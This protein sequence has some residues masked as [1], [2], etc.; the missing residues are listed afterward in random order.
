M[1]PI[2]V[3]DEIGG[4]LFPAACFRDLIGDPFCGWMSC[5]AKPQNLSSAVPHDQQTIEQAK[6]NCRHDEHIHRS[7]PTSVIVQERLP[8][9]RRWFS[10]FDHI[11]GHTR[12]SDIDAE[13]SNSPWIRGAPHSGLAM[14]ISRISLRI[15]GSTVGRPP[16]RRDFQRQYDLNP[17]RCH[18]TTVSGFTIAKAPSTFGAKRYKPANNRRS[19]IPNVGRFGDCRRN[20]LS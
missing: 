10:S 17:A 18:L 6:R 20:T 12:L 19:S 16:L 9:L 8:T 14:L 3:T 15:S 1:R 4:S 7:D 13:L 2:P 11:L 5:D